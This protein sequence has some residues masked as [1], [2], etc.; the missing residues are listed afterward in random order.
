MENSGAII[1]RVS[2]VSFIRKY[3]MWR[4]NTSAVVSLPSLSVVCP[5]VS[6]ETTDMAR[7]GVVVRMRQTASDE[8]E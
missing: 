1:D 7:F 4:V 8:S 6:R 2:I 3:Y 5:V